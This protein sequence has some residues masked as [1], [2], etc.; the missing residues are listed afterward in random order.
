MSTVDALHTGAT[1]SL[2]QLDGALVVSGQGVDL[3]VR[4]I[5]SFQEIYHLFY[6]L[7]ML[8]ILA[9]FQYWLIELYWLKKWSPC[10]CTTSIVHLNL[11]NVWHYTEW[12]LNMHL[13]AIYELVWFELHYMTLRRRTTTTTSP[14]PKVTP[15]KE[16]SQGSQLVPTRRASSMFRRFYRDR[17]WMWRKFGV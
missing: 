14:N 1:I 2:H 12:V 3:I 6:Y 16:G 9:I 8:L 15:T 10:P 11:I 5:Q 13:G 17:S 4:K 7:P